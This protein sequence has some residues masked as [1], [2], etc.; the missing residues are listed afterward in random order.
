MIV[1]DAYF[2]NIQSVIRKDLL[3]AKHSVY[4]A[5]A[6]FT[7]ELLF[8][9][10]I[11]LQQ[12]N[13]QV[14]LCVVQD[15]I[16]FR[17][18]GLPFEK[19]QTA[20]CKLFAAESD[21]MHHKF[22]V[23]DES[24]VITGSYNWTYKAANSGKDENIIVTSGDIDLAQKFIQEF[25][26]LTKQEANNHT[27]DLSR[28]LKRCKTILHLIELDEVEDVHKQAQRLQTE[29]AT[30]QVVNTIAKH[31][32]NNHFV[33][34]IEEINALLARYQSL[35]VYKDPLIQALKLEIKL[36]EY[37]VI[38][39]EAEKAE[40]EKKVFEYDRLFNEILGE[41][42]RLYLKLKRKIKEQVKNEQPQSEEAQQE[43]EE[44]ESDYTEYEKSY[45]QTKHEAKDFIE[46]TNPQDVARLKKMYKEAAM[47]CHP[48]KFVNE[49]AKQQQA[50][51]IFKDLSDAYQKQDMQTVKAI[52]ETLKQNGLA[53]EE[54]NT[55][56][57]NLQILQ[58]AL[59][60]LQQKYDL[61]FNAVNTIKE[62]QAYGIVVTKDD[63]SSYF[64]FL[65]NDIEREI[66]QLKKM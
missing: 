4:A 38:A 56:T 17:V 55:R 5:I 52:L 31:L 28:V 3:M 58:Q 34:A 59:K 23:I 12:R 36:L 20:N 47:L 30:L 53:M 37:Q 22:C 26:K 35:Q 39:L 18:H 42:V 25:L 46:L 62:S 61:L 66:I 7:D 15:E 44:A 45:E 24:V 10:L 48:D 2:E 32:L 29:A 43:F 65:K 63:L 27:T 33:K 50:E 6:W 13:I 21:K 8:D 11:E 9:T 54:T 14:Q 49:P 57:D 16:N 60:K 51:E 41:T 40:A 19:L 1:T 64:T